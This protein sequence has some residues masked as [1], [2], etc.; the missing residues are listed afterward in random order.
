LPEP[1]TSEARFTRDPATQPMREPAADP[2]D[3]R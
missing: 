1:A 3:R 2:L